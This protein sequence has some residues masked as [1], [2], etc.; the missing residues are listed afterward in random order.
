MI[1]EM[2]STTRRRVLHAS[3]VSL[4]ALA[5]C[6]DVPIGESCE[7][8]HEVSEYQESRGY[9]GEKITY[10]EL[11]DRG[12]EFFEKA[13][14]SGSHVVEYDGVNAPP[15]FAYSDA[16]STYVVSYEGERYT[17]FTYTSEG[18]VIE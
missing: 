17:L 1:L 2:A 14:E 11:S 12:K 8:R 18:C 5:G 15:D 13:L 6:T 3:S 16:A 4:L 10:D 7:L 9:E